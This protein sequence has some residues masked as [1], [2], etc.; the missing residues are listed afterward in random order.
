MLTTAAVAAGMAV[1]SSAVPTGYYDSLDGKSGESLKN[2][3]AALAKGHT[4]ITYN[5]KTW[6]AFEKTDVRVYEGKDIWW[7]MYSNSIVYTSGHDAMNIEHSVA[8]SWWGGENGSVEAYS[9]L[10]HLNPSEQFANG[11]KSNYPPGEV[12]EARILDNGLLK[13]GTPVAGQGGDAKSV[14][15]PADEYKGDFARAYFYVFATYADAPWKADANVCGTDGMLKPWAVELLLKWHRQDPVDSKELSRNE[16]VAEIQGNRNA[17]IDYPELAEYVWGDRKTENVSVASLTPVRA[18][19]RPEA[20]VFAG[21][22]TTGVNTYSRRWW[23]G[24]EQNVSGTSGTL[25]VSIDGRDYYPSSGVIQIDA[26]DDRNSTH[27]YSAYMEEEVEGYTLRSSVARLTAVSRDPSLTDYSAGEWER[28]KHTDILDLSEG[29]YILLSA[30]TLHVMSANGGKSSTFMESAGMVDINDAGTVTQLPVDAATVTF[31]DLGNG[32]YSVAVRDIYGEMKGWWNAT[33]KNKMSL[34]DVTWTP[35]S[36]EVDGFGNFVFTFDEW[37]SLQFNKSTPRFLNYQT[38]QG[39]V[40]LY[41][42]MRMGD[43]SG[44]GIIETSGPGFGIS[45]NNIIVGEGMR[46]YDLN[47]RAT[48]GRNL[49]P[50]VYIVTGAGINKKVVL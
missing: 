35:G 42:F 38:K 23:D 8:K 10:F 41:K 39:G 19:D 1:G 30:N 45:G 28:V 31:G 27:S 11:K 15:E 4:V 18:I 7:D 47:G 12:A 33:D 32:K 21:S 5:T 13:V 14:F 26:A 29:V 25:M 6:P 22:R 40:Y 2:A 46:V 48:D 36:G 43:P 24:Y 49:Q 34:D 50:G 3:I 44:V 20:P 17:F 16:A 9:D 37:G